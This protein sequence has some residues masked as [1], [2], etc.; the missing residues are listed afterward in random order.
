MVPASKSLT[1]RYLLLA[2]LA[3]A[4]CVVVNPLVSRDSA[5]MLAGLEALGA[6][7][8][9]VPDWE[10]SGEDAVRLTPL[11]AG[12]E[13]ASVDCGLAGTVMRF[14]PAVAALSGRRVRFDGDPEAKVRPMGA[15]LDGLRA[16]GVSVTEEGAAGH[17]PFTVWAAQGITGGEV[18]IDASASSQFVSGLLLAAPR[19]AEGLTL[20]HSGTQVP[21]LEHVQMTL[22][23]LA[24]LGVQVSSPEPYTWR[25]EPGPIAPF[26]VRVEPDLS[27]AGPF[28]CAAAVTGG[29]VSMPGWPL[30]STQIGRRWTQLLADFGCQ[31]ELVPTSDSTGTLTVRGPQQ[32]SSPG[33]VDGTAEL[34]PTVAALAA[35]CRGETTFT[36]IGH[37]RGHETDRIS[38]L[39]NEIR[40]LGGEAEETADGFRVLSPVSRA[41][42]VRSYADHRMATFGAVVGLAVSG[43]AVEDISCT[44]KTMPDFPDRW[45]ALVH[46]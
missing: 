45:S 25:V 44:A 40:R 28:L 2:G 30:Q 13:P 9:A 20:R 36:S 41:A 16:L 10:A 19:M 35:L 14:L 37:L 26:T 22:A 12:A 43:V 29:E 4:P 24:E 15:V 3:E 32:L 8:E 18:T 42:V 5:L 46:A 33:T 23:V 39:V 1:N 11:T 38:A 21:S 27:N 6:R 34:T 7:T 17:L 31:V